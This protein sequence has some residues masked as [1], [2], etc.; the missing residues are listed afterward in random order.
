MRTTALDAAT[1]GF[2]TTVLLDLTAGVAPDTVATAL[3]QLRAAG[4]QLVGAT[5]TG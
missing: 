3:E 2:A 1:E 4:L 5:L